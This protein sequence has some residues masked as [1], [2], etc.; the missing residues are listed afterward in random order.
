[1]SLRVVVGVSGGIAAYKAVSV[2]REFVQRGHHVTVVPTHSALRFVGAPTWEAISRNPVTAEV[3]D[4]VAEVKHV[5]LGQSADLIVIA[6]ASAHTLASL[7]NGFA[8]DLLGTTVLASNAPLVLAPAMHS[9]MWENPAVQANIATLRARGANVV[10]PDTGAL[11][12]GDVGV[13]RM[14]EPAEIVD[15]ALASLRGGSLS[16]KKVLISGG[17]TREPLDPVRF[18]GNRSSGAMAVA[19]AQEALA[20]GAEVTLV[21]AHCEVPLPYRVESV[22]VSSTLE[23]LE[24]MKAHQAGSDVIIMAAAVADW[25]AES[26]SSSKERGA[27]HEDEWSP[28]LVRTPD[29]AAELGAAK[30]EGQILLCFAA[31]TDPD[32]SVREQHAR[33]KL[34]RKQADAIVLNQVGDQVGFGEVETEVT[35]IT[36]SPQSQTFKGTKTSVAG[37]LWDALPEL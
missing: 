37:R 26:V 21:H 27:D 32:K 19:L 11:T 23:M 24:A 8:A 17:G 5:A 29:I 33:V 9:E 28:R 36:A 14:S 2:V 25:R 6:P 16:G 10:G 12:G 30:S 4:G 13:G 18:L 20:R 35:L 3:F 7:A 34:E 22:P 31:E 15:R 1:M